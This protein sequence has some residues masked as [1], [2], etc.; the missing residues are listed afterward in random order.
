MTGAM[1]YEQLKERHRAER[2]AWH[3]NLSLRVHRELSWLDRA[4]EQ[5]VCANAGTLMCELGRGEAELR[6]EQYGLAEIGAKVP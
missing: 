6:S 3:P 2:G 5:E 1:N 4:A